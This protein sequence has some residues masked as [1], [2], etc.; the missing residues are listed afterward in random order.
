MA[1]QICETCEY[2]Y[3]ECYCSPNSTCKDYEPDAV[4][5]NEINKYNSNLERIKALRTFMGGDN[6][7]VPIHDRSLD[8]MRFLVEQCAELG[9]PQPEIFPWAGGDGVQAEWEYDW[10]IE[11]NISSRGVEALLLKEHD[12]KNAIECKFDNA[13]N[14]ILLV[15]ELITHVVDFEG[16]R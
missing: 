10:Y 7:N 3:E 8:E 2:R 14:A 6:E 9:I 15:K 12:Y 13:L 11:I 5:F 4:I 1:A 16:T